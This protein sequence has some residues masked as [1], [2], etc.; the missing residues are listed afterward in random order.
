MST[1]I[2]RMIQRARAPLSSLEPIAPVRYAP[3]TSGQQPDEAAFAELPSAPAEM[4]DHGRPTPPRRSSSRNAL[5]GEGQ[6]GA[7][8]VPPGTASHG[9]ITPADLQ[10]HSARRERRAGTSGTEGVL[11]QEAL[12]DDERRPP[13]PGPFDDA[14]LHT[15]TTAGRTA[16]T[17]PIALTARLRP[18]DLAGNAG[19]AARPPVGGN[20]SDEVARGPEITVTIGH[21]EVRAASAAPARPARTPFRPQ[22]SLAD[23]L[24]GSSQESRR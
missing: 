2:E 22:V 6:R 11:D 15:T 20:A 10:P 19:A 12:R 8:P 4:T 3:T 14:D 24:K 13:T 9:S 21:I 18:A 23:F 7:S 16:P 1:L 17:Q 5:L